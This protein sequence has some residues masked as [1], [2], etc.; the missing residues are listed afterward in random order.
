MTDPFVEN[1]D[2]PMSRTKV[3]ATETGD[4]VATAQQIREALSGRRICPYCGL[5]NVGGGEPCPRCTLEDNATTRQATKARIGP[6]Y[7]LQSRNPAAP[8]MKFST[9]LTLI[10]RG[11][12]SPKSVMRGPTTYQLWRFAAHVR[13]VS[14]EFG[15]CFSCGGALERTAAVCPHCERPQEPPV[16]PD[17]LLDRPQSAP[18]AAELETP[19][20]A[21]APYQSHA[22]RVRELNRQR[23]LGEAEAQGGN[24]AR[25]RR[26]AE[27]LPRGGGGNVVSAMEL[28]AALQESPTGDSAHNGHGHR[29]PWR[30]FRGFAILILLLG[31]AGAGVW[32]FKPELREPARKFVA[33][34]WASIQSKSS[35]P[36]ERPRFIPP[37]PVAMSEKHDEPPPQIPP[38]VQHQTLPEPA[39]DLG[40]APME[41]P[42]SVPV[43]AEPAPPPP[44]P[45]IVAAKPQP[46]PPSEPPADALEESRQLW[47]QAI[48]AEQLG[49]YGEAV[50]LYERIKTLPKDVWPSAL[51][52]YLEAARKQAG[53]STEASSK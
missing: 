42:A 44:A 5:Q 24:G 51:N 3:S 16:D 50:R 26:R 9:L 30:L 12:I 7:L 1:E 10:N 14:R 23:S 21:V 28:A 8:G 18:A 29:W 40:Q 47:R 34:A 38:V 11:H 43:Q 20:L 33:D 46:P 48:D 25:Q 49:K 45:V 31:I 27:A 39:T 17:M 53:Q 13:G 35:A 19:P 36:V 4:V 15:I 37:A 2:D 6:W 32:Y 41:K 52:V 22:A